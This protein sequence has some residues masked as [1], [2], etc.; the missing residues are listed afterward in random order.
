VPIDWDGFHA[1]A[2]GQRIGLP[3]TVFEKKRHW[4]ER[5]DKGSSRV[6]G[7]EW[8][9][10][11][12]W[13]AT[14]LNVDAFGA[15]AMGKLVVLA[16]AG[17]LG[18][19]LVKRQQ[20]PVA[21]IAKA[22]V[23]PA[24][25]EALAQRIAAED[26]AVI[27]C[28][29]GLDAPELHA[30]S[31]PVDASALGV[32]G[33]LAALRAASDASVLVVTR[34]AVSV[35]GEAPAL[36][37]STLHGL[38]NVAA[39][40]LTDTPVVRVDL[41]PGRPDDALMQLELVLNAGLTEEQLAFREGQ[42]LARRLVRV[43][44]D[45]GKAPA[46]RED[47]TYLVT[48]GLG[49][50]GLRTAQWLREHGAG[51]IVLT[52]RSAP[53]E[54]AQE[55]VD[56]VGAVVIRSDVGD[57]GSLQALLDEVD[58]SDLPP[59]AGVF[60]AA[61]V[62]DDGA[63]RNLDWPRFA[64]IL[65]PKV[66]GTWNLHSRCDDLELFVLFSSAAGFVGSA[67]QA[68][69]AAGNT[70][71][72]A[73]A[74]ARR[75]E[76]KAA[77]SMAWGPWA[78]HGLATEAK[79]QWT[80]GG[81]TPLPPAQ[82]MAVM[83][84]LLGSPEPVVAV[85]DLEWEAW[86]QSLPRV[87]SL[88]KD[89]VIRRQA[90]SDVP[91]LVARVKAAPEARR[92][93]VLAD[94]I[95][96]VVAGVLGLDAGEVD[97][98]LGFFD[99]GL[100]SLMAVEVANRIKTA[101]GLKLPA[102][103]AFDHPTVNEVRD[104]LLGLLD[105]GAPAAAPAPVVAV[106]QPIELDEPIAVI[107][108]SCRMPG[109]ANDPEAFWELLRSGKD[110]MVR[111]PPERWDLSAFYDPTPGTPHKMY[112]KDAGW[113]DWDEVQGFDPEFFGISPREAAAMDPQQRM[114]LEVSYE[115]LERAGIAT[116]D[117]KE[118]QTGVFVGAGS[119]G[120]LQRF[121][122]SGGELYRDMYAGTGN[123]EAF[124]SG[125]VAYVLGLHG[126]NLALNTACSS[127]LVATHL[128]AQ[129]L[130]TGDC[131]VALAGG[132]HL[133]LS[134][135]NFV[136]VSQLK[137]LAT[138]GR[139]KTFDARA[140]GYGRAEGCGML[141]LKRLSDAQRDGDPVLAVIRGTAVNHDG[142][143]SGLT[144]P[145]GPAQV[146]VLSKAL[147]RSGIDPLDVSYIECHGTGT[148][149]GD[150]IEVH[151]IEDVYCQG[152]TEER[153]LYLGAAKANVGHMEVAAGAA[154]MVKMTL[155]L[156]H[157]ELPPQ[158]NYETPNPDLEIGGRLQVLTEPIAWS[159]AKRVAGISA[160]GLAGTNVHVVME[161]A[162]AQPAPASFDGPDRPAHVLML[163][164]RAKSA[165]A[166]LALRYEDRL[167]DADL[168]DVAFSAHTT[169]N[170][171]EHRVAVVGPDAAT[172][173]KRLA[174][175]AEHGE[176]AGVVSGV[177]RGRAPGVVF[178]FS[179]QG[180][181]YPGMGKEL[182]DAHPTF[183]GVV[184][185]CAAV[186]EP[187]LELPL[188]DVMFGGVEG[189]DGKPAIHD[190]TYTQP[191]LFVLEVALAELWKSWG[192]EPVAVLGHSIGQLSA[193]CV[194]GVF[195]LE[196]GLRLVAE[197]GRL[198][199]ALPRDGSMAA[200]FAEGEVVEQA[201]APHGDDVAVAARNN[202]GETVISG[203]TEAVEAVV[204]A[205]EAQGVETR[206]LT[207]SHAFHSPLMDPMLD[208]FEEVASTIAYAPPT[209]PVL[210][211]L[212][213]GEASDED[214]QR[215]GYWRDLVRN[216]VMFADGLR[217]L[218]EEGHEVFLEV[219][220]H[221]ALLGMG[222]RTISDRGVAWLGSMKRKEDPWDH[223]LGSLGALFTRGVDVDMKAFDAPWPRR[224]VELP[225]Y[226]WQRRVTWMDAPEWPQQQ[227]QAGSWLVRE[228]W[229]RAD[230][231][232]TAEDSLAGR[233]VV[234]GEGSEAEAIAG[235]LRSSGAGPEH[236]TDPSTV[237][238]AAGCV[239]VTSG[240][241]ATDAKRLLGAAQALL[242]SEGRLALVT[243]G[244]QEVDAGVAD[245]DAAA[246]L[247]MMRA[248]GAEAPAQR[249]LAVDL[250][251]E[252]RAD[253]EDR[254]LEA[255]LATD[256]EPEVAYRDEHR[257]VRRLVAGEWAAEPVSLREDGSYLV[258]GGLGGLGLEVAKWLVSNG[259]K[260]LYLTGRSA[261]K[262]HAEE[263]LAELRDLG[264]TVTVARGDVGVR[265]DVD[266]IVS[267]C[268]PALAGVIHAAGVLAD[269]ALPRQT[270]EGVDKVMGPKVLGTRNLHEAT[271]DLGLDLFVLYSG[272][273]SLLG[274]P[275]QANY[276]A[277]NAFL[278][279][280]ASWRRAQGLPAL[281]IQWGAWA[282]VG[283][284][285]GLGDAY[286]A[287]QAKE[288][289][290]RL[291]VGAGMDAMGRLFG[292]E[293]STMGVLNVDW[294][295]FVASLH[296]GTAPPLLS[297]LVTTVAAPKAVAH[298]VD[299]VEGTSTVAGGGLPPMRAAVAGKPQEEWLTPLSDRVEMLAISVLGLDRDRELD[300]DQP[301]LDVGLDSLL[302]VELKN[303][304]MDDGVDVPVAR[305]MTGPSIHQ[306]A[307]MIVNVL[308][309]EGGVPDPGAVD[310]PPI[311]DNA[312][313]PQDTAIGRA[314]ADAGW[315]PATRA[316]AEGGGLGIGHVLGAFLLGAILIPTLYM[317]TLMLVG[318][319]EVTLEDRAG[320][321]PPA[322]TQQKG[323]SKAKAKAKTKAK[324]KSP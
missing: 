210:C 52:G 73:V 285:A 257:F 303:R 213:G 231:P 135:E 174:D 78:E 167:D 169:R 141:V 223:V 243:R 75:A 143:S 111:V 241:A 204:A 155:A 33:A 136:Y 121:Q 57:A 82:G 22:D 17:G 300:R 162:P 207:V 277:A 252:P 40:E 323:K 322:P 186:L 119:S 297:E 23:D 324:A 11:E 125:R 306:V 13:E 188:L 106:A 147:G 101:S 316:P 312:H 63:L 91:P 117:L 161:E 3:G 89:L 195:S 279:G 129:A 53:S 172:V 37:Q 201:M 130:R 298:V 318:P 181:Q 68:N 84:Q 199:G 268:E 102:T 90:T 274:S 265:E 110:P 198:M 145:H 1:Q 238:G 271:K 31:D 219:G 179:G 150:P 170:R 54:A 196:D 183:R 152:R 107:G 262:P 8:T 118:S 160:F 307:Q 171:F 26:P 44:A 244:A 42:P 266:R 105:L 39:M 261:P 292:A 206:R 194:A 187:L 149:L 133:M 305:V 112:V 9:Y 74:Q 83:G 21:V 283:M 153:P 255:I 30:D 309:A 114:L 69:Y 280:F 178:L 176:G 276:C 96:A 272:G 254:L 99:M 51:G 260:H 212:T 286:A 273:A 10:G 93:D 197:R 264:A 41:D 35:R 6:V 86:P 116:E 16:D 137:A 87:P 4:V 202:P 295:R 189:A 88:V 221:T 43:D 290:H 229:H 281:S 32:Q 222:K 132:V 85:A 270:A 95:A 120:Y 226:P 315:V 253:D 310:G 146:Q 142:P 139:C 267:G 7:R 235:M 296:G 46:I 70:F 19:Q 14:R 184:D 60:H 92:G 319:A 259:A 218:E 131:D 103:L 108:V 94:G 236:S 97:H 148:V 124:V 289:I 24:D 287:Q 217:T 144:V 293:R 304:M 215:P 240:D 98:G 216:G 47:A 5:Q 27:V 158:A 242:G 76:G 294:G 175:F 251:V 182:Y 320:E 203:K 64:G 72:D 239:V 34:G 308:E 140:N 250:P 138:D 15:R 288:G 59:L 302:A 25:T 49:A 163:S 225:T 228:D 66:R 220:P 79:R 291:P 113:I 275:G 134:P 50:L 193:A 71:M 249:P 115:A 168:A 245:P 263:I 154:S 122:E 77:V 128:A 227:D 151:A 314:V 12:R 164:A 65:G 299:S 317:G 256:G 232:P 67:G 55:V 165:L 192:V 233:W 208:A 321:E 173:Q 109:G 81:V 104:H 200:L 177:A 166:E 248:F 157:K 28:L 191:C 61:G 230:P 234:L 211:N 29:W 36:G 80:A 38:L 205:V 269:A 258:T 20:R 246:L 45:P 123:L 58:G 156:H 311:A 214:L 247:G 48:G 237:A 127:S 2:P 224:R 185:R 190:T 209:V 301:L 159:N 313:G 180:S 284:A 18:A 62:L 56:R 278:D 282:D 126:P 100:D